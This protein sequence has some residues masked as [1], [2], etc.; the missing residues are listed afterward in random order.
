MSKPANETSNVF[1]EMHFCKVQLCSDQANIACRTCSYE[2]N[3]TEHFSRPVKYL[4]V[5]NLMGNQR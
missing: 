3:A 4:S 5:N 1:I 2:T